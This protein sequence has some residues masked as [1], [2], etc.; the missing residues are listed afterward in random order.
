MST[1]KVIKLS[2]EQYLDIERKAEFKSEYYN[3]EMFALAGASYI[4]NKI[5]RNISKSLGNQLTGKECEEF[6][7]D[8]KVKEIVSKLFTYPDI[9]VICGEPEF[10]DDEK[11]VITNPA[12]IMEVLSKSTENYDRG[13]KFELYRR[14]HSLKDYFLVSQEKVSVEYYSRNPDDSWTLKEFNDIDQTI[15]IKS[16]DCKLEL[17]EVY[18][19]VKFN[20]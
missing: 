9:V 16:I 5:A 3:G 2:P 17:K 10:H 7:S 13:S 8:L 1:Q 15:Q 14:I 20:N 12:L 4:H 11:D 19:K 18:D 6:Q